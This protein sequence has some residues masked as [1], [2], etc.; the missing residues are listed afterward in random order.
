M[1]KILIVSKTRMKDARVCVGG[2]DLDQNLSVRLLNVNGYHEKETECPYEVGDIWDC[3]YMRNSRRPAPHLEDSNVSSRKLVEK[4]SCNTSTAFLEQLEKHGICVFRGPLINCFDNCLIEDNYCFYVSKNKTPNYSTCFWVN[5]KPL[6]K[7][8]LCN[9][10]GSIK[11]RLAYMSGFS[12]RN[13]YIP[14]VGLGDT[15][16]IIPEDTLIRLSLAHWWSKDGETEERCY[17]QV[18]GFYLK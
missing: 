17:L 18:S 2:V 12:M 16:D 15:P 7:N 13:K 5:D 8:D 11:K 4:A 14:Y 9:V 1:S 10:D 3:V 6:R